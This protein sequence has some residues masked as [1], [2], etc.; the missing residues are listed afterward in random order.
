VLGSQLVPG[1]WKP[2]IHLSAVV[3]ILLSEFTLEMGLLIENNEQMETSCHN[4]GIEGQGR[5]T[6]KDG[7]TQDRREASEIHRI[8]GVP[9]EPA[10]DEFPGRINWRWRATPKHGEI[11]HTPKINHGAYGEKSAGDREEQS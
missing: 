2:P 6:K 5:C 11:P 8:S 1:F 10:H 7:P 9:I 3:L 4:H